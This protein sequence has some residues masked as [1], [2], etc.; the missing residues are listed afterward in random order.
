MLAV[1]LKKNE[2][3][4]AGYRLINPTSKKMDMSKLKAETDVAQGWT[5]HKM[6]KTFICCLA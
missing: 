2:L 4:F 6:H 3:S 1:I 5:T